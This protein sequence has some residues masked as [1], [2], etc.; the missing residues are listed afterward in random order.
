MMKQA[1]S[2]MM[3][4]TLTASSLLGLPADISAAGTTGTPIKPQQDVTVYSNGYYL[5]SKI[6]AADTVNYH[7]HADDGGAA[8]I[9]RVGLQD[10][11][12]SAYTYMKYDISGIPVLTPGMEVELAF[13]ASSS[14]QMELSVYGLH[15]LQAASDW[16]E[17]T[18][19]W[20]SKFLNL[21]D[22]IDTI[23]IPN[24]SSGIQFNLTDYIMDN[25]KA[26][27]S[28]IGLVMKAETTGVI[29]LRG[30][31]TTDSAGAGRIPVLIVN[32]QSTG[33]HA[34]R[35]YTPPVKFAYG[36]NMPPLHD[37]LVYNPATTNNKDANKNYHGTNNT[38]SIADGMTVEFNKSYGYYKFDISNLPDADHIGTTLFSVWGRDTSKA[39]SAPATNYIQIYGADEAVN[40]K[41]TGITWNNKPA[42]GAAPIAEVLYKS[43]ND[44]QDADITEYVKRQKQKGEKTI[45]LMM[46]AKTSSGIFYH[47]G[48]DTTASGQMPPRL[49][50]A[51]PAD[52][53]EDMT[54][55]ADGRSRLYPADWY[56]GFKD[57]KG[58]FLHD[59]SYAGYRLGEAS[60]PDTDAAAGIDVTK[61]PYLADSTGAADATA[62]IQAAINS[63]AAAGGGIVYLPEGT[64]QVNPQEG[65]DFSLNIAGSGVV[66][67][68]AGMNRTFVYNAAENMKQKD[69]IRVGDGDWKKTSVATKLSKSVAEPTVLLPV[70][71]ASGFAVG[72]Y[73]LIAFDTTL[74]FLNELGMQ[75]KWASRLGKVEPLFYRQIVGVDTLNRTLTLDIP[76]RYA[77]KQR[78]NITITKTEP[79]ISEVGIEDF[80]IAN[81]QNHNS[82]LGEDDY[83]VV[84]TA[85]YETDNAKVI[86]MIAVANS[87][88]RNVNTY[89]PAGNS[90]YHILSKGII[91]D[92]TKN[93]T[94]DN[95][96][97][98]YPQ[99]RGANGNGYLYQF[100]GNDNLIT[101]SKAIAARHSFTY[102]NFSSNGNVLHNVYSENSSLMT[103]FHMYLSMANLIDNMTLNGDG[104]SAITRDYGSSATNR[105]GVVTTESVFWNTTGQAAH[106]S[107]NGIIIESEQFGNGYIIGTK[108]AV[109]GVNVNI[110]GSIP[111]TNTKPFDMAEGVGEGARL[112]PQSLYADQ[113][114]RRSSGKELALQSLLVNGVPIGG[115]QFLT[116][117]YAYTL[118][119][120]TTKV[121]TIA[122]KALSADAVVTI[123]QPAA[124]NGTGIVQVS[125]NGSV[126]EYRVQFQVAASPI[127]PKQVTLAPDKSEP[128]WRAAGN[129][130]SEGRSGKLK[131]YLTLDNGEVLNAE[132][133]NIPVVYRVN[134][135]QV[136]TTEGNW[137]KAKQ[138]GVLRITAEIVWNGVKVSASENFEVKVPMPEPEGSFAQVI[139]VTASEDDGNLPVNTIDRDPDSRWSAEGSEQYLQLELDR[140]QWIDKVSLLFYSGNL[141][142]NYFDLEVS[143]DGI[144]YQRVITGATSTKQ[145]P[146]Q[147]ETFGFEPVRAKYVKYI[148]HG[149]E[150]NAWNSIIECWVHT[151]HID[152]PFTTLSVAE[153]VYSGQTFQSLIGLGNV[154]ASVYAAVYGA[155]MSVTYDPAVL[156][157][158]SVESLKPG[159]ILDHETVMQ[160]PGQLRIK[161]SAGAAQDA[162]TS[163]GDVFRIHWLAKPVSQ[164]ATTRIRI[165]S[166]Q[167]TNGSQHTA[168][169]LTTASDVRVLAAS[170]SS[171]GN[172]SHSGSY[173]GTATP[174]VPPAAPTPPVV[175]ESPDQPVK[176]MVPAGAPKYE[177]SVSGTT[178]AKVVVTDADLQKAIDALKSESEAKNGEVHFVLQVTGQA[179]RGTVLFPAASFASLAAQVPQAVWR[180]EFDG[181]VYQLPVDAVN[182]QEP[183]LKLN[184]QSD[185]MQIGI[186]IDKLSS[187]DQSKLQ[188]AADANGAKLLHRGI[189]FE[190]TAEAGGRQIEVRD[191]GSTYAPRILTLPGHVAADTTAAVWFDSATGDMN[192]VPAKYD[193]A[194]GQT[195][196]TLFRTG[197]SI[198]TVVQADKAFS[199]LSGHWARKQVEQLASKFLVH[200][201]GDDRFIPDAAITR[202]EFAALVTRAIGLA[203]KVNGSFADVSGTAWYAGAV[204][205]A[206]AAGIVE[207]DEAHAFKPDASITREE[208]AV[209]IVRA[210]RAAGLAEQ[211][212]EG[213][214]V[215]VDAAL[216]RFEDSGSISGYAKAA[217][218]EALQAGIVEGMTASTFAPQNNATRAEAAVMLQRMLAYMHFN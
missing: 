21:T 151:T 161:A 35:P 72:D 146:N 105:H 48:K 121:P 56:P 60:L 164:A 192:F 160:L 206:S 1:V 136:G 78:D 122:A 58:R 188:A 80:S 92:R 65:K 147:T 69:I 174:S 119:Y 31:E 182:I 115:M 210:L 200:G 73:V 186:H 44:Y 127:M 101:N 89:K 82:G 103:D 123:T 133:A 100:I 157:F 3:A 32:E 141:R 181:A 204:G 142:S 28:I 207:G 114:E 13:Q 134:N 53:P 17:T 145:E 26:G 87:W 150:L 144:H 33:L 193:Y 14:E 23:Q 169:A 41:E 106:S 94:V 7:Q 189:G 195:L 129:A 135:E 111:D 55:G 2:F 93:V 148:G 124:A 167:L 74:D 153:S 214:A 99:Y 91:L 176:V 12:T 107:K 172:D 132:Q 177:T 202:A 88:V 95:V 185:D 57:G 159:F 218:S 137:F 126:Q 203:A 108:G 49:I 179:D 211:A 180:V 34:P 97:M 170:S 19:T 198:Y 27:K 213:G 66:L 76:T 18:M 190:V 217:I 166:A 22:S 54:L 184:A 40:W 59:F 15:P 116:T 86:N 110:V 139:N 183:A 83:K 5:N 104:I 205:A 29:E 96:T 11:G 52:V 140:E 84:G 67:K 61:A 4:I 187:A 156:S 191:F 138:A 62:A 128:G 9:M 175:Q 149:N 39:T 120:G 6:I 113:F 197:N 50:V 199:D 42:M 131:A 102:A 165:A 130:I 216:A 90:T 8:D 25:Q 46:A 10:D 212:A 109:T 163:N 38:A 168:E 196:V 24:A 209:M 16:S 75:N 117:K 36:K 79:P 171:S 85:G 152:A 125:K 64:Y 112:V 20:R 51:D 118:P 47:R 43:A 158:V 77:L 30:H 68:G 208:M 37:A 81:V 63:A 45:T 178:V 154:T 201:A 155:E 143:T 173:P 194:D 70:A 71:D 162:I 98:Q 215:A